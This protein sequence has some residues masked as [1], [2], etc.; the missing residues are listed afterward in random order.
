MV[1]VMGLIAQ[2]TQVGCKLK[3]TH[4]GAAPDRCEVVCCLRLP[5]LRTVLR[6]VGVVLV[7][8]G[9]FGVAR[10][11]SVTAVGPIHFTTELANV[12]DA[13]KYHAFRARRHRNYY[14]ELCAGAQVACCCSAL[15]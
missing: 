10:T 4:Q 7:W 13:Y 9:V 5:C 3:L 2:A 8:E 6:S 15:D 1:P 12:F 14:V 11:Q